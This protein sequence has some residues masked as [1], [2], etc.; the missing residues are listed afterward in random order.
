MTDTRNFANLTEY[1][2]IALPSMLFLVLEWSLFDIQ[3]I[4]AGN[5]SLNDQGCQ[6][7]YYNILVLIY[8]V[9]LGI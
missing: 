7:I 5:I 1:L 8:S 9:P 3:T 4:I 6:I 2:A